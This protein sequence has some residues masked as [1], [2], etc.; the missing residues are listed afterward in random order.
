MTSH[1]PAPLFE[2]DSPPQ[3]AEELAIDRGLHN[4]IGDRP[5]IEQGTP[6]PL[7]PAPQDH[8]EVEARE[9]MQQRFQW[10]VILLGQNQRQG[11]N[12]GYRDFADVVCLLQALHQLDIYEYQTGRLCRGV[13]HTSTGSY[14]EIDAETFIDSL[15][16]Q[17]KP[18]TWRNK[19]SMYFRIKFLHAY[20][21]YNPR[22]WDQKPHCWMVSRCISAWMLNLDPSQL[23]SQD[24]IETTRYN[25]GE[26]RRLL[27]EMS[28]HVY[29]G[30][31]YAAPAILSAH[32]TNCKCH[33]AQFTDQGR[34]VVI[35][36]DQI[37]AR[38]PWEINDSS[39]CK[40]LF[41]GSS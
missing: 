18:S 40:Y 25:V 2:R 17:H 1:T 37:G 9:E 10:L 29:N 24:R 7:S 22:A 31:S 34:P 35:P 3:I 39:F 13:F 27:Q 8:A 36:V 28:D 38:V 19:F 26:L 12:T 23:L 4:Q 6:L 41:A 33:K 21:Q 32:Q 20:S 15:R 30:T 11:W 16:L 14:Y 5:A